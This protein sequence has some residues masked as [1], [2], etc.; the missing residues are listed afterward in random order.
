MF[1]GLGVYAD[2]LMFA[3]VA[4]GELYLKSGPENAAEFDAEGCG[5]FTYADRNGRKA[6]MSYRLAP[7]RLL[8]DPD[9][10]AVWAK[11][12]RQCA[13]AAKSKTP[14]KPRG[15]GKSK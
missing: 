8:D 15:V 5:P 11:R 14:R 9:E 10:M 2:D 6:V 12:A 7:G 1:G 4:D 13:L 3:L